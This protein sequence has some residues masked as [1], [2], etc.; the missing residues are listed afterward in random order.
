MKNLGTNIQ[1]KIIEK[2]GK[3][4]EVNEQTTQSWGNNSFTTTIK[5]N[6]VLFDSARDSFS[7]QDEVNVPSLKID[8]TSTQPFTD[9]EKEKLAKVTTPM[10]IMGRVDTI[11]D[12]PSDAG[13]GEVY[14]VGESGSESFEEYVCIENDGSDEEAVWESL[15]KTTN[16]A[17]QP[18]WNQ[19]DPTK[20][21]YIKNRICYD[22][23]PTNIVGDTLTINNSGQIVGSINGVYYFNPVVPFVT[24]GTYTVSIKNETINIVTSGS[25]DNSS[26]NGGGS[27]G[28]GYFSVSWNTEGIVGSPN[29]ETA[30]ISFYGSSDYAGYILSFTTISDLKKIDEKYIPTSIARV[31]DIPQ[32]KYASSVSGFA[33][34]I[35]DVE[36]GSTK[37]PVKIP[38]I[39]YITWSGSTL[40]LESGSFTI[41]TGTQTV[42]SITWGGTTNTVNTMYALF[43]AGDNFIMPSD[44]YSN[45]STLTSGK[46][47]FL[48]VIGDSIKGW[49]YLF[50]EMTD[51]SL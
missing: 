14:L 32:V 6:T 42:I 48:T 46:R 24:G 44:G 12:L 28:Q 26:G 21:D 50:Q 47:Y 22:E 11:E 49:N 25:P 38:L 7:F 39:N 30:S 8:G 20:D 10:Q 40:T 27:V 17:V 16:E 34:K 19:N 31:S 5:E 1:A 18:D 23:E 3:L 37:Y 13:V 45:L 35:G 9:V 41:C 4:N 29:N 43:T 15:G 51:L 2:M 33:Q 36:V